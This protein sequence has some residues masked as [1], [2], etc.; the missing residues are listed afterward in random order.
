MKEYKHHKAKE[1]KGMVDNKMVKSDRQK[2]IER[3]IQKKSD[4]PG[5]NPGKMVSKGHANWKRS[6]SAMTPRKA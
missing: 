2:G 6:N 5:C 4:M 3:V 1:S